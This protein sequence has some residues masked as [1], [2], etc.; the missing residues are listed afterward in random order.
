MLHLSAEIVYDPVLKQKLNVVFNSTSKHV[1]PMCGK[2]FNRKDNLDRHKRVHTGEKPFQCGTCSQ[3]LHTLS[4]KEIKKST[5]IVGKATTSCI[6][7]CG[8]YLKNLTIFSNH[9]R[10]CTVY[11]TNRF[12]SSYS[13]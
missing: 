4:K 12:Y 1:C 10:Y 8:R 9:R 11:K 13:L 5:L 2:V 3:T 7:I 6:C